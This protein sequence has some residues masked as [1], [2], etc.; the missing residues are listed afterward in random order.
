MDLRGGALLGGGEEGGI[1]EG[2]FG[3][4]R[5]GVFGRGLRREDSFDILAS[6]ML[7]TD[8]VLGER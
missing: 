4:E 7:R 2:V 6:R 3:E 8:W 1:G 5:E